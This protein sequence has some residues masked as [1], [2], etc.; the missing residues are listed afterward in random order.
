MAHKGFFPVGLGAL[1][2]VTLVGLNCS[3][4][5]D[6]SG[7]GGSS[8]G[9]GG[10]SSGTG[11]SASQ[12]GG[13]SSGTGGTTSDSGVGPTGMPPIPVCN[14]GEAKGVTPCTTATPEGMACFKTCGP[15]GIG[16]KAE[17]CQGGAYVEGDC[18]F[19]QGDYSCYAPKADTPACPMGTKSGDPC[20]MGMC[21]PCGGKGNDYLDTSSAV[22]TGFCICPAGAAAPKWTCGSSS[23][24]SWPCLQ[25][26]KC[27]PTNGGC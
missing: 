1:L 4:S 22:K 6:T 8:A 5:S 21:Q 26:P 23:S 17:T 3:S 20:T 19:V 18:N 25:D 9:T 12:T 2:T 7:T 16:W 14:L 13:S 11:G 24:C 27:K 15:S 10:T